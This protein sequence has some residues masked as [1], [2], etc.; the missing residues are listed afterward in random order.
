MKNK[1][2]RTLTQAFCL[3]SLALGA[4]A[5]GT[6]SMLA[7]RFSAQ[8]TLRGQAYQ[9][10]T[11]K[12][13]FRRADQRSDK[14]LDQVAKRMRFLIFQDLDLNRDG[15]L[16]PYEY[17][18]DSVFPEADAN[19]DGRVSLTEFQ[20]YKSDG[21]NG[22]FTDRKFLRQQAMLNWMMMNRDQNEFVL[23]EELVDFFVNPFDQPLDP[24]T[25]F[26]LRQQAHRFFAQSDI[27]FDQ[28]LDRSEYEDGYAKTL[29]ADWFGPPISGPPVQPEPPPITEP[30]MPEPPM[31][32]PITVI[33]PGTR[34]RR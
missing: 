19:Q 12:H 1:I 27:N 4:S 30:P 28:L 9:M 18:D 33:G 7:P 22:A 20:E 31:P 10:G 17:L 21:R 29:L 15:Y 16:T 34:S 5:C 32:E 8:H 6:S 11:P 2:A 3:A 24:E 14:V 26:R 23:L 25:E 13:F